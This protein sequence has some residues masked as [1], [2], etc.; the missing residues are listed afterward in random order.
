[1]GDKSGGSAEVRGTVETI[2]MVAVRKMRCRWNDVLH[3]PEFSC[4]VLSMGVVDK[5]AGLKC[6][7]NRNLSNS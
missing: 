4:N 5:K 2:M 6:V 3:A 1:M 7:Q